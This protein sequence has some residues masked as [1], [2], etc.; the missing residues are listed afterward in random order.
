MI[1]RGVEEV[2]LAFVDTLFQ[3]M[4]RRNACFQVNA[5]AVF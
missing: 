3:Y 2:I 4:C 5:G 1:D